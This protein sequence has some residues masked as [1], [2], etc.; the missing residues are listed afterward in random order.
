MSEKVEDFERNPY[1]EAQ[2]EA[3]KAMMNAKGIVKDA[4]KELGITEGALN[5]R[6]DDI[7]RKYDRFKLG[8]DIYENWRRSPYLRKKLF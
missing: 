2:L 4:A 7:R 3:I 1:T 8:S 6:M 5:S